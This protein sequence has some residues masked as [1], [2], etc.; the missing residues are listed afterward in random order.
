M[1]REEFWCLMCFIELNH[2]SLCHI[3]RNANNA[4]HGERHR[5]NKFQDS[6]IAVLRMDTLEMR[7]QAHNDEYNS[8]MQDHIDWLLFD[9][10]LFLSRNLAER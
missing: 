8:T 1:F 6:E 9:K 10:V 5:V 7:P 2:F 4:R 3:A